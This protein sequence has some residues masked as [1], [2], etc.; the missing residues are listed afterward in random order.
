LIEQVNGKVIK[1][2]TIPQVVD[3]LRDEEGT[4]VTLTVRQ[5]DAKESRT[6]K[7]TRVPV[8]FDTIVGCRRAS[9]EAWSYR[10]DPE[11]PIGYLRVATLNAAILHDLRQAERRLHADGCKALILDLRHSGSDGMLRHAAMLADA[12][13]D[14]G[15]MWASRSKD[16]TTRKEY[17]ADNEC[18]FRDWPLV[19]L[20]DDSL[21]RTHSLIG[22][23]L[24]DNGRAILVGAPT[25]M[26][27]RVNTM[28]TLPDGKTGLIFHSG[29][30]ERPKMERGWPLKP[31]HEVTMDAKQQKA[32]VEWINAQEIAGDLDGAK[33]PPDP[34]LARAVELLREKLK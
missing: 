12:L 25:K 4:S 22:A 13:L 27:G 7:M 20:I 28:V 9:D 17:R 29:L 23:A 8:P 33:A 32:L 14:G 18:L 19:A 10:P 24:Q 3:L 26:D 30:L 6:Y 5:P 21:D 34:Q 2:L 31:D 15:L 1:G 16:D 11:L